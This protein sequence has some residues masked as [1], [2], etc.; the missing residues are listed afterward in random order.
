MSMPI[1]LI[2]IRVLLSVE[3]CFTLK[4]YLKGAPFYNASAAYCQEVV[5]SARY[6]RRSLHDLCGQNLK[7]S[8]HATGGNILDRFVAE[9]EHEHL[10]AAGIVIHGESPILYGNSHTLACAG[11]QTGPSNPH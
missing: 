2:S 11:H 7:Q 6:V 4:I 9:A 8:S 5:R 3:F 10:C 1:Y